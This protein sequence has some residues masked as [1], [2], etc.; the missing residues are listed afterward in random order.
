MQRKRELYRENE[1]LKS[2]NERLRE[3][4]ERLLRDKRRIEH[5]WRNWWGYDGTPQKEGADD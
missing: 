4:R 3:E 1:R 2:D 5:E